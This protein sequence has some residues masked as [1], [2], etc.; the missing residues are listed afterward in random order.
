MSL[1]FTVFPNGHG[2]RFEIRDDGVDI[3]SFRSAEAY[4]IFLDG[5][6]ARGNLSIYDQASGRYVIEAENDASAGMLELREALED[7]ITLLRE[8]ASGIEPRIEMIERALR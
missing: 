3:A 6:R 2:D 4:S 1:D 5:I 7:A 8:H